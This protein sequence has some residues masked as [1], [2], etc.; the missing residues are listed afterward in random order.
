VK[1]P[2]SG[3]IAVV[4]GA[5]QGIGRAIA[6]RLAAG[7][8]H[9]TLVA[10]RAPELARVQKEIEAT[11][12]VATG[13]PCDLRDSARI[14]ALTTRL[15]A[16]RVDILVNV[17]GAF[18]RGEW[19]DAP[20]DDLDDLYQT[21]VRGIVQLTQGVLPAMQDGGDIVFINSTVVHSDGRNVAHY[22]AMQHAL[23][24]L[25]NALRAEV[26]E[27]GIRVLSVYPGR[28]ATPRQEEIF[29]QEGRPYDA[30]RLLQP[31]DVAE[32]VCA[33]LR[34]AGTAEVTGL[35]IRPRHKP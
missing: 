29:R 22:A 19:K 11:G 1:A 30:A 16:A 35:R 32:A 27:Y 7:G 10:R 2:L 3:K 17:G 26:N 8:A 13:E 14:A 20:L 15:A 18:H 25:A 33:C 5:T 24:G 12:G 31:E 23:T 21:N 9:V 4:T 28:T 34:L 6:V